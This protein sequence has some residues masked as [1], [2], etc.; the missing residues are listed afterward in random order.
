MAHI[1]TQRTWYFTLCLRCIFTVLVLLAKLGF[2]GQIDF[3]LT[4]DA[5][6][7]Q[8]WLQLNDSSALENRICNPGSPIMVLTI[9][10]DLFISLGYCLQYIRYHRV[11][12]GG[13]GSAPHSTYSFIAP[14]LEDLFIPLGY[15]LQYIRYHRVEAGGWGSAPDSTYS[16]I[17]PILEDLFISL[18]YSL[19][20]IRYHRVIARG[21][22]SAPHST[23]SFIAPI[24]EDLFI[25]QGY[26]L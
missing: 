6:D 24:L 5:C 17:A 15:C 2:Y 21:W 16:F 11:M 10:E 7:T 12:A 8:G 4:G 26:S 23:Y 3:Q 22:G 25:S 18:G 13:W 1:E 19:Q 20:Y 14:I 9:L